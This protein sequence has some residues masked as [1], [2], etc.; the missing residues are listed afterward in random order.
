MY[1]KWFCVRDS[2]C[3]LWYQWMEATG[4]YVSTKYEEFSNSVS[5]IKM[6]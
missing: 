5:A 1:K 2:T 4:R 3:S 6:D